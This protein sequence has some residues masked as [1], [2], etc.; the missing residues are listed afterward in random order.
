MS[1]IKESILNTLIMVL[2]STQ[3][4]D[5]TDLM[6]QIKKEKPET[7]KQCRK[8]LAWLLTQIENQAAN[9]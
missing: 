6:E 2:E 8:Q 4:I 5:S 9:D 1:D 7:V 3:N